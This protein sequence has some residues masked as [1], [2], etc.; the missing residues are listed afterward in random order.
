MNRRVSYGCSQL[1]LVGETQ[2]D[3]DIA[4]FLSFHTM[5]ISNVFLGGVPESP[6]I[7]TNIMNLH[8]FC[9]KMISSYFLTMHN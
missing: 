4:T 2:A 9:H 8:P 3:L 1:R 7:D 6:M 5:F